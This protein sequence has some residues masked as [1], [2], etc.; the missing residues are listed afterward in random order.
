V[1]SRQEQS[2]VGRRKLEIFLP[3]FRKDH[4]CPTPSSKNSSQGNGINPRAPKLISVNYS[5]WIYDALGT[6][7]SFLNGWE[8]ILVVF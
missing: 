2:A 7:V 4:L 5:W 6:Q 8:N 1:G 3:P